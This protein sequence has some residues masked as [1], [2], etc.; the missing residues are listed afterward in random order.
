LAAKPRRDSSK[1]SPVSIE[2][3]VPFEKY[4]S[5]HLVTRK[6][7]PIDTSLR[8][9]QLFRAKCVLFGFPMDHT[10]DVTWALLLVIMMRSPPNS[11]A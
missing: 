3:Q 10:D 5:A 9:S 4:P 1:K 8:P 7:G 6:P 11:P 2:H